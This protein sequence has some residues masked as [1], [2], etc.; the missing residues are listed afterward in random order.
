MTD[1]GVRKQCAG[2]E[3]AARMHLAMESFPEALSKGEF[4]Q[5][6]FL[7]PE[8]GVIWLGTRLGREEP[9]DRQG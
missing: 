2:C 1:S 3:E 9:D 6:E 8:H 7:C 4:V 5:S